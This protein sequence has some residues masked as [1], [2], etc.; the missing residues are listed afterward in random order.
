M[1]LVDI[2]CSGKRATLSVS[3]YNEISGGHISSCRCLEEG[4]C[5]PS[6]APVV[7]RPLYRI[8]TKKKNWQPN[9]YDLSSFSAKTLLF[10]LFDP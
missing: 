6:T 1:L 7:V 9:P 8:Y 4:L 10:G 3:Y 5:R 2:G